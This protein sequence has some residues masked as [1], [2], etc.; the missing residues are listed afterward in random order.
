M[1]IKA[2][3]DL[4]NAVYSYIDNEEDIQTAAIMMNPNTG[5][6]MTL[7]GGNNYAKSQ[8]N[9]ATSSK[10]SVDLSLFPLI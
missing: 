9:R 5:G 2:Q 4:E 10:S 1:D 3:E 8:Y 6:I 7:I